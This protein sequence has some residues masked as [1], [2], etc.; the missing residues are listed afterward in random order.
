L[1]AFNQGGTAR[2]LSSLS[3]GWRLFLFSSIFVFKAE[4]T[5]LLRPAQEEYRRRRLSAFT[6]IQLVTSRSKEPKLDR[7]KA[8]A[9]VLLRPAQEEYQGRCLSAFTGIQL[10]TSRS[11]EP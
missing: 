1:F 10:V 8:E 9:T 5:V 3:Q 4:A 2:S 7:F 11:K 6:G